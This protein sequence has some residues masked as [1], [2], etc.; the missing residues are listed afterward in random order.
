MRRI[1]ALALL[2]V[3]AHAPGCAETPDSRIATTAVGAGSGAAEPNLAV[4]ADGGVIASWLEPAGEGAHTLRFARRGDAGAWGEPRTI[5]TGEHW[6][7]NWADFPSVLPLSGD[8]LAAHWLVRSGPGTY[9]YDVMMA[10][11]YDGGASWSEPFTPHTDGTQTEHGFVA[12]FPA[13][14]GGVGAVWLD[15]REMGGGHG[16][17]AD[18]AGDGPDADAGDPPTEAAG[19]RPGADAAAAGGHR[20]GAMTLRYARF[21]DAGGGPLDEA[22]LDD[23]TCDCCQN[24]AVRVGD[25]VVVAYRDRSPDEVRDIAVRRG[26][27]DGWE[28]SRIVHADGWR[29]P[30]CPVNGPAIAAAGDRVAVAWF[31]AA[32]DTPRVR[33]AFSDDAGRSFGPPIRVDGGAPEGRVDLQFVDAES[34]AVSWLERTADG[35]DVRVRRVRPDGS[36]GAPVVITRTGAERA[37]GFPRFVVAGDELVFAWTRV[38]DPSTVLAATLPAAGLPA[39]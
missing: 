13:P 11:S 29:I 12:L 31:T 37:S 5:A 8:T 28:P 35:A 36:A 14:A 39:P 1:A 16:E 38:G 20:G 30:A 4:A 18:G 2:A 24:D 25:A 15:G 17:A 19:D 22:L 27:R 32:Q 10:L 33:V 23:R 21:E 6:F 34:A 7:V 26:T 3:A 9:A